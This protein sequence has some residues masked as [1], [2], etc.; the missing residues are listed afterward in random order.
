MAR[1]HYVKKARKDNP[2][3]KKGE[4][5]YWW[6]FRFG[7]KHYSKTPP[8]GS[9]LTQ[10]EFLSQFLEISEALDEINLSPTTL[11]EVQDIA[12]TLEDLAS[13]MEDLASETQDKQSALEDAFPGGCPTLDLL[14]ERSQAAEEAQQTIEEAKDGLESVASDVE[15]RFEDSD[16]D[17]S[18]DTELN[19]E[20]RSEAESA[21][22]GL[23]LDCPE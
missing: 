8:K 6:A 23:S 16:D 4:P 10:S 1:V 18:D 20:E 11:G 14:E 7:G 15:S 22:S 12:S 2:A 19:D 3:V 17:A 13:Q 9:Q 5:Y 21:L